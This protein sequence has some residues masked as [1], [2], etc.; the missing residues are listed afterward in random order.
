[1]EIENLDFDYIIVGSG[2]GGSVSA[3]RLSQKGY[4]VA[5]IESGKRWNPGDYPKSN[6]SIRKFLWLPS[7]FCYG[8]QRL[9]LLDDVMILSGAGVGGGSLVYANTLYIP[10]KKFFDN[11]IVQKMGGENKILPFYKIAQKMLGVIE[12]P[13]LW[14]VD[15][16]MK[17]TAAHFGMEK[18][19]KPTPVG[20]NFH[21]KDG[22]D[23]Y[24]NGEGPERNGCNFCGACMVGCRFNAKNTLDKN[25]LYFAE[26]LGAVIIPETQ[27]ID[28]LPFGES[29]EN[30]YEV[31][32]KSTTGL[33]GSPRKKFT[34]KGIVFSAGVL[35]TMNLF[36]RL[37][38]KNRLPKLSNMLGKTVRTNS[39]SILGVTSLNKNVNYSKGIAIT[40]SIYPDEDTHIE[41]VR[42]PEGSD[43]MG[44]LA[45]GSLID[46]GGKVPRQLRFLW[47]LV[48]H[49]L[50]SLRFAIPFGFAKRSIILLVMQ[51]IDNSIDIVRKRKWYWPFTRTLGSVQE[52]GKTI[53]TYIPIANEFARKLAQNIN[54]VA[55]SSVNEVILN[56]P[57]TAH[58]LGGSII[59]ESPETGVID[60][61]NRV[62]GYENMLVCDGSMV[63]ANLGVNPSLTITALTE[64]AMSFIS[65]KSEKSQNFFNYEKEW[66]I[67][68]VLAGDS[69][70]SNEKPLENEKLGPKEE[71]IER[72]RIQS[73]EKLTKKKATQQKKKSISAK[74]KK[75]TK[76]V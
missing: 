67:L 48:R 40:S 12:N 21:E 27:V 59:G 16:L 3:M 6:F 41:P 30:G 22:V 56:I 18:T 34:T 25:Y 58:V 17:K 60:L 64:R 9:N 26:K 52:K 5:I 4:K 50:R 72:P 23:P 32:T 68:D 43:A 74:K 69:P 70:N 20:I 47:S 10:P 44:A 63:P 33:F 46:G 55:R 39:E 51:A 2:F 75:G 76:K 36:L 61:Q 62:F 66:K 73:K 37:K 31:R 28:V 35:G 53:P 7:L 49:P 57:T 54:G 71:E 24:F 13:K 11:S 65:A 14:E 29:G 15:D 38:E 1:M 45:A 42:Y 8:I 19:F